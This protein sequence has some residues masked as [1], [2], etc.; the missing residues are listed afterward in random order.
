M[1]LFAQEGANIIACMRSKNDNFEAVLQSYTAKYGV[2]I[3]P[4]YFDLKNENSIKEVFQDIYK[5]KYPIDILVNNAGVVTKG[6]FQMTKID[7]IKEIFQIN[8]FSQVLI[9]Q[10]TLK[11][12]C[13]ARYGSIINMGSIGGIDAY[14]AYTSYGCSKA[15]LM[16]FTKTLS[17]EYA[18]YNIRVNT[19]APSMTDTNMAKEM[20]EEA[21]REILNRCALK[22]LAKTEEIAELA[23]FLA[24]DKSSFIT[25][26]TI[27]IDGGL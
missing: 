13:K 21:N 23:L 10:Y 5:Q 7:S 3:V 26:Q 9:T 16:Y 6:L 8:F 17:Q 18:P 1:E 4:Y 2:S 20:G 24:S 15:A 27:R 12:M 25:G 19:I 22:R 11:I 14:P